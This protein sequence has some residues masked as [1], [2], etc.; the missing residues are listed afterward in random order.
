MAN[1]IVVMDQN[2]HADNSSAQTSIENAGGS[3]L[4]TFDL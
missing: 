2:T 4:T 1:Y 3:V